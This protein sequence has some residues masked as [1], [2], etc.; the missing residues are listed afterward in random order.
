[1][2]QHLIESKRE[3]KGELGREDKRADKWRISGADT[4]RSNESCA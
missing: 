3:H 1:M 2:A 4:R